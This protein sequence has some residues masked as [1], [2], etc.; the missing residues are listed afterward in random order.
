MI[1]RPEDDNRLVVISSEGVTEPSKKKSRKIRKKD[2]FVNC[3]FDKM[4]SLSPLSPLKNKILLHDDPDSRK[5]LAL[6]QEPLNQTDPSSLMSASSLTFSS[7][8]TSA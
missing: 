6:I 7:D 2:K 3:I 1:I 4:S 5:L 8:S